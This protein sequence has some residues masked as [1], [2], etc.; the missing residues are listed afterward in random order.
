MVRSKDVLTQDFKALPYWWEAAQPKQI[1]VTSPVDSTDVAIVGSGYAGLSAAL[2]LARSGTKTIV[3]DKE[4]I[5]FG[6]STRNGGLLSTEPKFAGKNELTHRFGGEL[7]ERILED[8]RQSFSTLASTIK[9]EGINCALERNG[10][11]VGAH[12][13][14][15]YQKLAGRLRQYE[16][17]GLSGFELIPRERQH[18]IIGDSN[19]YYGGLYEPDGGSLHPGLYHAGLVNA[20]LRANVALSANTDVMSIK[21]NTS[22][23]VVSTSLG[24]VT[25]REVVIATNGYTGA[26]APWQ[27]RRVVPVGSYIVVTEVLGEALVESMFRGFCTMSNT[28]RVL[29][30]Y[31]PTPDHKRV[32]FGGRANFTAVDHVTFA[33]RLHDYM[34][35]VY[36]QLRDTKISHAWTGNVAFSFDY[37]PHMGIN[38]GVHY[39]MGCNGSGVAM[40]TYLGRQTALKILDKQNRLCA[41]EEIPFN[42]HIGY[43]GKPWFLPFIGNW[44]RLLDVFDRM[45]I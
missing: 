39:L 41:F 3:F 16:K 29:F 22:G 12:C 42:T 44:Y 20:C 26:L 10:R 7:A 14:R 36:P 21:R 4:A 45:M 27:R 38:E 9:Q 13:P 43:H 1:R 25:C 28:Q 24:E 34:S 5:G 19:Y 40:M 2:E 32:M 17:E 23:F 31:R 6:A 37:L 8:G 30:Y 35:R 33:T 15:A 18:E 11:F